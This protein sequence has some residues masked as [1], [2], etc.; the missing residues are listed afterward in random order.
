MPL[1]LSPQQFLKISELL[2][3]VSGICLKPGKEDFAKLRLLK[4]LRALGIKTFDEYFELLENDPEQKELHLLVDVMTTNKTEFFR[5]KAHFNYLRQKVLPEL[6]GPKL[7]FWS[8]GCSS[9]EEPFSLAILLREEIQEIDKLDVKILATDISLRMLEKVSQARYP[10]ESVRG[11][12]PLWVQKYFFAIPHGSRYLYQVKDEVRKLV[13]I[14]RLNLLDPW[15]M[16]GPFQVIFC[17][18]VMI[19]FDRQ[20]QQKL[21]QRFWEYLEPGG[22]LFLGHSESIASFDHNFKYKKPAIYQ[23]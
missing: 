22:Y 12:S 13:H 4:R 3:Q 8:A 16:K 15:P 23:K 1:Y 14:A 18:N 20:T 17:C 2:Y 5:E 9:G 10:K 7:R 11:I 19:Y 6:I 21:I